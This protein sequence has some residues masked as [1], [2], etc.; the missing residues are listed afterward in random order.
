MYRGVDL[1]PLTLSREGP[2][3]DAGCGGKDSDEALGAQV[4]PAAPKARVE[5]ATGASADEPCTDNVD[6][7]QVDFPLPRSTAQRHNCS[8]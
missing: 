8:L 7:T 4:T 1:D 5:V 3:G 2:D 6:D